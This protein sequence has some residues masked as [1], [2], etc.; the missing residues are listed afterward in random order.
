MCV[1]AADKDDTMLKPV[2]S[3]AFLSPEIC[4]GE[5]K[6]GT[7]MC[8]LW[9]IAITLYMMVYGARPHQ[10]E[11]VLGCVHVYMY[12]YIFMYACIYA[13]MNICIYVYMI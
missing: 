10:S 2:G 4:K 11:S 8:D 12:M 9:A 6:E 5:T 7:K 1:C 3:P 13:Y